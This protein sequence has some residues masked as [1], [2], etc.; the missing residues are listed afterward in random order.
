MLLLDDW[1]ASSQK[2][3]QFPK[4]GGGA[5]PRLGNADIEWQFHFPISKFIFGEKIGFY[6]FILNLYEYWNI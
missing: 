3:A 4:G 2:C 5:S 1:L 6:I